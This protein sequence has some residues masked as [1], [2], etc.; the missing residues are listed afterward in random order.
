VER[1]REV[2]KRGWEV[3]ARGV[4]RRGDEREKEGGGRVRGLRRGRIGRGK[5]YDTVGRGRG[6]RERW[7]TDRGRWEGKEGWAARVE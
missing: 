2:E 5:R 3:R 7:N 6:Q 1:G 4:G